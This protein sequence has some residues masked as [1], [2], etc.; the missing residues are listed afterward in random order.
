[1]EVNGLFQFLKA[2]KSMIRPDECMMGEKVVKIPKLTVAKMKE[3]IRVTENLPG[4]IIQ[5]LLAPREDLHAYVVAAFDLASHEI[6]MA[7]ASFAD[8]DEKYVPGKVSINELIAFV[9]LAL[10]YNA[11]C[12]AVQNVNRLLMPE[13][14]TETEKAEPLPAGSQE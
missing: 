9:K 7:V 10:E 14:A 11:L 13:A 2:K 3:I 4:M 8:L 6:V 1:M 12:Q 5:I